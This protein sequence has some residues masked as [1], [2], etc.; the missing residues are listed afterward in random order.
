M[1][2]ACKLNK[3]G[4]NVQPWHIPF[5][6]WN[7]SVVP[8]TILTLLRTSLGVR[9]SWKM[10]PLSEVGVQ[11]SLKK[12]QLQKVDGRQVCRFVVI[13]EAELVH[14][15]WSSRKESSRVQ[16]SCR[17]GL[18]AWEGVEVLVWAWGTEYTVSMV[19]GLWCWGSQR[20]KPWELAEG[21]RCSGDPM[22]KNLPASVGH[23]CD[24][25]ARK[26]PHA[27]G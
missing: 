25:G 1:Y 14:S 2:S 16:V 4:D 5:P 20:R 8:C 24:P 18:G 15:H 12:V 22:V 27:V 10:S 6:I 13:A 23:A 11:I 21:L 9:I 19:G 26:I 17:W 3:Q 7:Q